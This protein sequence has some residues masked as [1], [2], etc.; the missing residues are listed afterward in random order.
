MKLT[1]SNPLCNAMP[2]K[3][4]IKWYI[5]ILANVYMYGTP[6]LVSGLFAVA[7]IGMVG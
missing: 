6:V 1:I 5:P 2:A 7:I 3:D 4:E